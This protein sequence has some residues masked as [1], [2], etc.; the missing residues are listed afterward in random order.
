MSITV[1][2]VINK[3][4]ESIPLEFTLS[5]T[6]IVFEGLS[7]SPLYV[8]EEGNNTIKFKF[9]DGIVRTITINVGIYSL[10]VLLKEL[11]SASFYSLEFT[12][13]DDRCWVRSNRSF[14]FVS[15]DSK[16]LAMLGLT[17]INSD[18][19]S[20]LSSIKTHDYLHHID[21]M[22]CGDTTEKKGTVGFSTS[23]N[24]VISFYKQGIKGIPCVNKMLFVSFQSTSCIKYPLYGSVEHPITLNIS[25]NATFDIITS[26]S[27]D[28][29]NKEQYPMEELAKIALAD[30]EIRD[31]IYELLTLLVKKILVDK[32]FDK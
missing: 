29:K 12:T 3:V 9:D 20:Y 26:D 5:P 1:S 21:M 14:R 32:I 30:E 7:T 28:E 4:T 15:D 17:P 2:K 11:S 16:L 10:G 8:V 13:V 31:K 18:T 25:Y 6:S 27:K 19:T 23:N 24:S 22:V